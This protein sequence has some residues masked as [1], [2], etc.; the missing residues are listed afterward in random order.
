MT[1]PDGRGKLA[2][3]AADT[4]RARCP[5]ISQLPAGFVTN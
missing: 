2:G 3:L 5:A 4:V 1:E